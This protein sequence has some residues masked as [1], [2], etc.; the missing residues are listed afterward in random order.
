MNDYMIVY[1]SDDGARTIL[2]EE[3]ADTI[4]GAARYA[5]ARLEME[6]FGQGAVWAIAAVVEMNPLAQV[7]AALEAAL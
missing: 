3:Q 2:R 7:A 1:V 6:P 4:A 5:S